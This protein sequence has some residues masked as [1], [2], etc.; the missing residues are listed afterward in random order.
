MFLKKPAC[1]YPKAR[2]LLPKSPP[3]ILKS[4]RAFKNRTG[5]EFKK[6]ACFC[7]G[8]RVPYGFNIT[9]NKI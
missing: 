3:A 8:A 4:R 7:P 2:L 9:A 5:M 6:P 1:L